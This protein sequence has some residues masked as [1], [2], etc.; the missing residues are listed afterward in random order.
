MFHAKVKVIPGDRVEE[1]VGHAPGAGS[2]S[3]PN[4]AHHHASGVHRPLKA[5]IDVIDTH[6]L[7]REGHVEGVLESQLI[8]LV[9]SF[10]PRRIMESANYED[11]VV[12]RVHEP[13]G[14]DNAP[15]AHVLSGRGASSLFA[16]KMVLHDEALQSLRDGDVAPVE[17]IA[18]HPEREDAP[19]ERQESEQRGDR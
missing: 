10:A 8:Q 5:V 16:V 4:G 9:R 7:R 12:Q 15:C 1:L 17:N 2:C 13:N 18:K 19:S 3:G 14:A 11:V 6:G